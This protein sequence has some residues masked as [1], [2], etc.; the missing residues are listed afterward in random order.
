MNS[1]GY[2]DYSEFIAATL[3]LTDIENKLKVAFD[4]FD[5]NRDGSITFDEL[6]KIIGPTENWKEIFNTFDSD[7]D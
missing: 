5:S 7:H 2:L 6:F 1:S 3:K 4:F